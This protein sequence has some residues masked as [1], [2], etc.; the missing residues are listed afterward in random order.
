MVF[1]RICGRN[2]QRDPALISS[3][4]LS[5][6][7]YTKDLW[8]VFGLCLFILVWIVF[9]YFAF[10]FGLE[11]MLMGSARGAVEIKEADGL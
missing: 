1:G 3:L 7:E 6:P 11:L 9:V 5:P 2:T 4:I 8:I 10:V